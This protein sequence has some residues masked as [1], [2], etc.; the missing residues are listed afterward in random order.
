MSSYLDRI[1]AV[2]T[3]ITA[4][5][6][7]IPGAV[8]VYSGGSPSGQPKAASVSFAVA[9]TMARWNRVDGQSAPIYWTGLVWSRTAT[10]VQETSLGSSPRNEKTAV[11]RAEG[12]QCGSPPSQ[13][14]AVTVIVPVSQSTA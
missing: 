1:Q 3:A 13:A 9:G 7:K 14:A 11:S 12:Q 5:G 8:S 6:A 2:I 10:R 4:A